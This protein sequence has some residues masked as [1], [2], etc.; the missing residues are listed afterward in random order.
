MS[1]RRKRW[2]GKQRDL[3]PVELLQRLD[4]APQACQQLAP[5]DPGTR[6]H[7]MSTSEHMYSR[8]LAGSASW[9]HS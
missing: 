3:A 9:H 1:R 2:G 6:A 8:C 7:A 5:A 4:L